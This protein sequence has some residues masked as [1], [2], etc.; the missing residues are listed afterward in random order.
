MAARGGAAIDAQAVGADGG[1]RLLEAPMF[2]GSPDAP[3][4]VR[5]LPCFV[6]P[7]GTTQAMERLSGTGSVDQHNSC[8]LPTPDPLSDIRARPT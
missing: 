5:Y 8:Y 6:R 7:W 4:Q 2:G 1:W 3:W